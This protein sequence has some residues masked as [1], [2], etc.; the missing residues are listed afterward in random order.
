MRGANGAG[1]G[2]LDAAAVEGGRA[3]G[4]EAAAGRHLEAARHFPLRD[5]PLAAQ[6][7]IGD[8]DGRQ[9]ALRVRMLGSRWM[10]SRAPTSTISPRYITA[11]RS[12][13][14][15]TTCRSWEMKR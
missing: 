7:G 12:D 5:D 6:R 4:M 10:A 1:D 14:C 8:G 3:A 2:T 13:M 9:Q 15:R 11:T